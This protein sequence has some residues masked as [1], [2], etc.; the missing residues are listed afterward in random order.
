MD[1]SHLPCAVDKSNKAGTLQS[2]E[3]RS[4]GHA[5][6]KTLGVGKVCDL[7]FSRLPSQL[8]FP[9][10][11]RCCLTPFKGCLVLNFWDPKPLLW[12]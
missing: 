12:V 4:R 7:L 9:T 2:E 1:F 10:Q 5:F 8:F 11:L 6:A 3:A